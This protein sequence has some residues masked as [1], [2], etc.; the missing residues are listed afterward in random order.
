MN[1]VLIDSDC[2]PIAA[3][4]ILDGLAGFAQ[5]DA[6]RDRKAVLLGR[7][8]AAEDAANVGDPS[9]GVWEAY[10]AADRAYRAA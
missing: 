1:F 3:T 10:V 7:L 8:H 5:R 9:P 6:V 2:C 4:A